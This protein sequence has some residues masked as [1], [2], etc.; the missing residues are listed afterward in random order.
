MK[1]DI[2]KNLIISSTAIIRNYKKA[3]K[4]IE[5]EGIGF[6]FKYEKPDMVLMT[7]KKYEELMDKLEHMEIY[8]AVK[9][10]NEDDDGK[11]YSIEEAM[12][13]VNKA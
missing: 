7:F 12:E 6:I 2:A 8:L 11:R 9:K 5:S 4:K 13:M 1:F 10:A 3:C